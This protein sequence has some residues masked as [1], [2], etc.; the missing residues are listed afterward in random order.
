[1]RSFGP[2]RV[3]FEA[4]ALF[5]EAHEV[6]VSP[7]EMRL[8]AYLM[9]SPGQVRSLGELLSNVWGYK[10]GTRTRTIQTHIKR[11]RDKLGSA[12]RLIETVRGAGYRLNE[13]RSPS[14][15]G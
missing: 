15:Y 6:Q 10:E 12:G 14:P 2:I 8:L 4:H 11:L 5:V 3:D 1:M 7:L 13:L 9:A